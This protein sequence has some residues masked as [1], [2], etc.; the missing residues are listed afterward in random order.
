M[1][2]IHLL[3]DTHSH[4]YARQFSKDREK[5]IERAFEAGV[6]R[7]VV[8]GIDEE[9]IPLAI[10]LAEKYESIYATVGWHPKE[11]IHYKEYHLDYLREMSKH[12]KVVAIGEMGLDYYWDTSPKDVQDKVFREQIRLA[13]E[14]NLPIIIHNREATDDVIHILQEEDAA[15]VGGIIHCY[16]SSIANLAPFLEMNFYISLAG[17]VTFKNV[18]EL[19]E[20]AK[21]I[22]LDRL[23]IE[24][25]APYLAP[26]PYRGKRNE[27]AYVTKVAEEIASL[28]E[29]DYEEICRITTENA[30]RVYRINE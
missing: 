16:S 6:N 1:E 18:K 22:P 26:H 4:L 25:D 14:V 23:L 9:T 28:R 10:E 2:V 21:H 3:F 17:P 7:I 5:M 11:A 24:T 12:E 13:K 27:P 8:V 29:M 19:K 15:E 20:V 30:L